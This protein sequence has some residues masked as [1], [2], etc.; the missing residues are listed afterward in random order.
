MKK[1]DKVKVFQKVTGQLV[2]EGKLGDTDSYGTYV[3]D[4]HGIEWQVNEE[5]EEIRKA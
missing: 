1:G 4:K 5:H 3:T 2:T